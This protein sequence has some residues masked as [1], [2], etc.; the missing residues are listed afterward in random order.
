MGRFETAI[1]NH[2]KVFEMLLQLVQK[3]MRLLGPASGKMTSW[4]K[5]RI[6]SSRDD[7]GDKSPGFTYTFMGQKTTIGS[8]AHLFFSNQL[9]SHEKEHI[10]NREFTG[11]NLT[12]K[13]TE[14]TT[15]YV[16]LLSLNNCPGKVSRFACIR[17][18][19]A[20][21]LAAPTLKAP[22]GHHSGN[23]H[24]LGF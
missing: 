23:A 7:V 2:T 5:Y 3:P 12:A 21:L 19:Y 17:E 18:K 8:K 10:P 9:S 20:A 16:K 13:A 4:E 1:K 6:A 22:L 14:I 24:Q 11:A 15:I